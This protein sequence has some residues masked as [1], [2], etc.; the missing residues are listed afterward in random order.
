[1]CAV[2]VPLGGQVAL[3]VAQHAHH[4]L[5][6][7]L[8]L[9][10]LRG[11][12]HGSESREAAGPRS[13]IM[14]A[15]PRRA[16]NRTPN[17][18]TMPRASSRVRADRT[19]IRPMPAVRAIESAATSR[20][21]GTASSTCL[22]RWVSRSRAVSRPRGR[23]ERGGRPAG[24]TTSSTSA[25]DV[26]RVAAPE[27]ISW[28]TPCGRRTGD[29]PGDA[30]QGTVEPTGPVGGVERTAAQGGL[31]HDR[32]AGEGRDQ[33]VAGQEPI[34]VGAHPGGASDTTAPV[35]ARWSSSGLW[36]AG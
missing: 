8:R 24:L 17:A 16:A 27:R 23:V 15:P 30:H 28:C 2:Q 9:L 34:R 18:P 14:S 29:R 21:T 33:P 22:C 4:R 32:A 1:M 25:P 11:L 10:V 5:G 31:D 35:P 7:R 19:S 26:T 6:Q 13:G 3:V 36:A 20:A 12:G